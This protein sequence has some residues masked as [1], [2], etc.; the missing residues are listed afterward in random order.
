M[1]DRLHA[2]LERAQGLGLLGPGPVEAH[3]DHATGFIR[4]WSSEREEPPRRFCDLGA[5][6]GVPG[7]PLALDWASSAGVLMDASSRRC[8]F[9]RDAI[10]SLGLADR[11][12]VAEGRAETLARQIGFDSSFDLV[13]ARSFARPA[14]T[15]ECG[16]R[17]LRDQGLFL[18][19]DPPD[20][21]EGPEVR[22]P[23]QGLLELGLR[24]QGQLA[25]PSIAVLVRKLACPERYP[26]RNGIPAKR[27]LF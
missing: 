13:T 20:S 6:G 21:L 14:V 3:L 22:W 10:R 27:P 4:A 11:I 2:V 8:A 16:A 9:L 15:A 24:L 7:L 17:L 5:G 1:R 23:E 18:V 12:E 26:R 19:A 25:Q